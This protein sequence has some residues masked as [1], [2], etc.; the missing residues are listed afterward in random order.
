MEITEISADIAAGNQS[1][2][3]VASPHRIALLVRPPSVWKLVGENAPVQIDTSSNDFTVLQAF[4]ELTKDTRQMLLV[5]HV[6][7]QNIAFVDCDDD[8]EAVGVSSE[9]RLFH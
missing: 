1:S 7:G 5:P 3:Q 4:A 2:P 8:L 6:V 9:D